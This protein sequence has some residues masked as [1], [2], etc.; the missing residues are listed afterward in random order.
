MKITKEELQPGKTYYFYTLEGTRGIPDLVQYNKFNIRSLTTK[1][2]TRREAG[3]VLWRGYS[4][5]KVDPGESW[6]YISDVKGPK[7]WKGEGGIIVPQVRRSSEDKHISLFS[8]SRIERSFENY[9]KFLRSSSSKIVRV[10]DNKVEAIEDAILLVENAI[11]VLT[12]ERDKLIAEYLGLGIHSDSEAG[13]LVYETEEAKKKWKDINIKDLNPGDTIWIAEMQ[14]TASRWWVSN[15][16]NLI[17]RRDIPPI[18]LTF[19][20]WKETGSENKY[21][22]VVESSRLICADESRYQGC[23]GSYDLILSRT[24]E[25]CEKLYLRSKYE[26]LQNSIAIVNDHIE[27]MT[28]RRKD[29]ILRLEKD[30]IL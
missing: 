13:K 17:S 29:L 5:S 21:F 3:S 10:F 27:R 28:D 2:L 25:D 7:S 11:G 9:T 12:E 14:I 30:A 1:E 20:E 8:P 22:S 15:I 6:Y 18:P 4:Y 23:Y 16:E 26:D 19:C 24:K